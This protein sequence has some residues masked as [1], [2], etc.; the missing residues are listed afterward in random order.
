METGQLFAGLVGVV[1]AAGGLFA[2]RSAW[3]RASGRASG[4]AVRVIGGWALL[5]VS[6]AM[7]AKA[8]GPDRGVALGLIA[9]VLA[10]LGLVAWSA[11][12]GPARSAAPPK[13]GRAADAPARVSW[14]RHLRTTG[15]VLLAGPVAGLSA[16]AVTVS[17]FTVL[18]AGGAEVTGNLVAAFFLLPLSWAG[19]TAVSVIDPRLWRKW[20]VVAGA[21]TISGLHLALTG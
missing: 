3:A 12:T 7:W 2:L 11:L 6:L 18:N 4:R 21:G 1:A 13:D 20:L 15:S 9:I 16:L 19:L 14:R 8:G 10:A 5:A 17:V